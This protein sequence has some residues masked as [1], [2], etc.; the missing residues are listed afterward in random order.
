MV[1]MH[2]IHSN[3]SFSGSGPVPLSP[4]LLPLCLFTFNHPIKAKMPKKATK[5]RKKRD[6]KE[7]WLY[8]KKILFQFR[9]SLLIF[10]FLILLMYCMYIYS[11]IYSLSLLIA[12]S[13]LLK[14]YT[15][16]R[17]SDTQINSYNI[18]R[19]FSKWVITNVCNS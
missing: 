1:T 14:T 3:H 9:N 13:S 11:F 12:F 6:L 19:K 18:Y 5:K 2:A 16:Y 15:L 7:I 4:P 17:Y 8:M 10:V